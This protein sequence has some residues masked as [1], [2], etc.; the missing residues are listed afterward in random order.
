MTGRG[1]LH[2]FISHLTLSK[3]RTWEGRQA[4]GGMEAPIYIRSIWRAPFSLACHQINCQTDWVLGTDVWDLVIFVKC[5]FGDTLKIGQQGSWSGGQSG[6]D[7]DQG[8]QGYVRIWPWKEGNGDPGRLAKTV[9]YNKL[10]YKFYE[11]IYKL[12]KINFL[13]FLLIFGG[14]FEIQSL[15]LPSSYSILDAK[16]NSLFWYFPNFWREIWII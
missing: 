4:C 1:L 8:C 12:Q 5:G 15:Y 16:Y 3:L 11:P 9:Q 6:Y 2:K 13:L 14:R 10:K 7:N